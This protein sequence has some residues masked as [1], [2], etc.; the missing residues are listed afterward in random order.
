MA[1]PKTTIDEHG[2]ERDRRGEWRSGRPVYL[3]PLLD[4]PTNVKKI[5]AWLTSFPGF[6]FPWFALYMIVIG[7]SYAWFTPAMERMQTL[8]LGWMAEVLLRNLVLL[9]IWTGAFHLWFYSYKMQ[10][11]LKKYNANWQSTDSRV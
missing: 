10:G 5:F 6:F 3:E 8:E 11:R 7:V 1:K 2:Q 4:D 9:W